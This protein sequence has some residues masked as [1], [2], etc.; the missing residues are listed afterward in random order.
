[1]QASKDFIVSGKDTVIHW[2]YFSAACVQH[3]MSP[4]C[5]V[6]HLKHAIFVLK[7]IGNIITTLRNV[8][9]HETIAPYI[10]TTQQYQSEWVENGVIESFAQGYISN[11]KIHL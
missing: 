1:M 7:A 10:C 11:S 2:V 5:Y 6:R 9:I 4:F 8:Y 3:H